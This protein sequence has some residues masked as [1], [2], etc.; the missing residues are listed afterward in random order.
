MKLLKNKIL[1]VG[2][3]ILLFAILEYRYFSFVHEFHE[4]NKF[5]FKFVLHKFIIA[6]FLFLISLSFLFFKQ[7]KFIYV[8]T[9]LFNLF[10]FIPN[11][12]MCIYADAPIIISLLILLFLFLLSS[13][14]E[15]I[16]IKLFKN[17]NSYKRVGTLKDKIKFITKFIPLQIS[18]NKKLLILSI[19]ALLFLIPFIITYGFNIDF[20]IFTFGEVIYEIRKQTVAK[21]NIF[22]NYLYSPLRLFLLPVII[23]FSLKYKKWL[24]LIF[25]IIALLY[26]FAI[27]PQKGTFFALVIVFGFYFFKNYFSKLNFFFAGIVSVLIITIIFTEKFDIY[28]PESILIRRL[29][30]VPA[31]LNNAYFELYNGNHIYLSHSIFKHFIEYPYALE[32]VFWVSEEYFGVM[33]SCNNGIVSDGYMNFGIIGSIVNIIV[34][35]FIFKFFDKLNISARFFGIFFLIL[36]LFI[37]TALLTSMLTH[38]IWLAFII[39]IFFLKKPKI[40]NSNCIKAPF[41]GL[42]SKQQNN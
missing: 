16:F 7:S 32:P 13:N 21:S 40:F 29:F 25:S 36:Q 19:L 3:L 15:N 1:H 2:I 38:G 11:A 8:I 39:S 24:Y 27:I 33:S 10:F 4:Y 30:F 37:S 34:A 5:I 9:I 17:S 28:M 31:L 35:V 23:I 20:R 41:G 14:V 12:I 42:G 26:L 22:T 6:K 18:A